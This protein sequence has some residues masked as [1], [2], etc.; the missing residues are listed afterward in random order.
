[1]ASKKKVE[2]SVES[3]DIVQEVDVD[4]FIPEPKTEKL[5]SEQK[6]HLKFC[7]E[8]L[9]LLGRKSSNVEFRRGVKAAKAS[10]SKLL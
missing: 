2:E 6:E 5:T 7:F 4:H 3:S 8:W 9:E 1:M 10:L